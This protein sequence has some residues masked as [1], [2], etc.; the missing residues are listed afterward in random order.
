ML[1]DIDSQLRLLKAH[2]D[3]TKVDVVVVK[4]GTVRELREVALDGRQP[5]IETREQMVSKKKK[6]KRRLS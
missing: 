6:E 4:V 3:G 1:M 2:L 5:E